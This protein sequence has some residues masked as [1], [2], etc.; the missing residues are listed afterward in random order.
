MALNF[1]RAWSS[2][3]LPRCSPWLESRRYAP[4]LTLLSVRGLNWVHLFLVP[5]LSGLDRCGELAL[6]DAIHGGKLI[7]TFAAAVES[8][9]QGFALGQL[10]VAFG[11]GF[12]K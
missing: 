3:R 2:L 1:K 5:A 7:G 4:S 12:L 6:V 11:E 8:A 9:A 10:L